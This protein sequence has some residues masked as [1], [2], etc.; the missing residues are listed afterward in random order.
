MG[1]VVRP[2]ERT[3]AAYA[4]RPEGE[5]TRAQ[6]EEELLTRLLGTH[7]DGVVEVGRSAT[8]QPQNGRT[9]M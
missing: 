8:G 7:V 5:A 9:R 3:H 1:T 2:E 6:G 4:K